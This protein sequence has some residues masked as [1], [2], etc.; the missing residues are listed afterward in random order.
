MLAPAIVLALA[1]SQP[2]LPVPPP[3]EDVVS[4]TGPPGCPSAADVRARVTGYLGGGATL[5]GVR[6]DARVEA[7]EGAD[8]AQAFA[9]DV[10]VASASGTTRHSLTAAKCETLADAVALV[11]AVALDPVEVANAIEAAKTA[12][13]PQP[14]PEPSAKTDPKLD[15]NEPL[16]P[17]P[18]RPE[19]GPP[20]PR[21]DPP[22]RRPVLFALR[23]DFALDFGPLPRLGIGGGFTTTVLGRG[24]RAEAGMVALAPRDAASDI[25]SSA[26]ASIGLIA[27]RARGC[28]VLG[29]SLVEFP[30]CGGVEIGA[31]RG[32][33][34][35]TTVNARSRRALWSAAVL[36]PAIAVVPRRFIAIVAGVEAVVPFA[37][38]A[39]DLGDETVHR[40]RVAGVRAGLAVEIRVP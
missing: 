14:E 4:F 23:P 12:P 21:Q 6:I 17:E 39:F 5:V 22:K 3:D 28:G 27:G 26:T 31:L 40:A 25:V 9:L 32:E 36:G 37:R 34:A 30:L 18:A 15:P 35:G 33:G 13:E 1:G 11:A 29:R 10:T 7:R 16:P 38:P 20:R 8:A 19:P 24:W 2:A